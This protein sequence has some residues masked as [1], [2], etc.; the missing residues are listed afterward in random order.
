MQVVE[1]LRMSRQ[2][3]TGGK[4]RRRVA[5]LRKA[6]LF[7]NENDGTVISRA[8]TL[9]DLRAAY[10]LTHDVF[11]AQG[12]IKPDETGLRMRVFEALP[13]TATFVAKDQ[14]QVVAVTSVVVDSAQLGIPAQKVF[15]PEVQK[16]RD[17]GRVI[18]EGTNWLVADSHRKSTA[19]TELMRC[20]FAHARSAGCTDFVGEVSP[21]HAKFYELLGFETIGSVRS[22]SPEIDDPVVLVRFDLSALDDLLEEIEDAQDEAQI[23]LKRYYVDE[24]PYQRFVKFWS[25]VAERFFQDPI[26]LHELFVVESQLLG[27]LTDR[28]LSEVES[29]WGREVFQQAWPERSAAQ[30]HS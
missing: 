19:M 10:R 15:G 4:A 21:G 25:I 18:C 7:S 22:S 16:L 9:E 27:R 24:N 11:V 6:G 26:L 1:G 2:A 23:F 20:C 13:D 12:Y 14:D 3:M 17:Q 30:A 8:S 28:E 5:L 29:R